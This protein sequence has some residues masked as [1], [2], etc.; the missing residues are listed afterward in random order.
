[1][2][3]YS[4]YVPACVAQ[5]RAPSSGSVQYVQH[6]SPHGLFRCVL[7]TYVFSMHSTM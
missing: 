1:M 3:L 7:P 5:S 6:V 4:V 2:S